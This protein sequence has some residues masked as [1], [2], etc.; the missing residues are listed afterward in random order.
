MDRN[1]QLKEIN[2]IYNCI[3]YFQME[4]FFGNF[5]VFLLFFHFSPNVGKYGPESLQIRA[6]FTQCLEQGQKNPVKLDNFY[7]SLCVLFDCYCESL[8]SWRQGSRLCL[9]PNLRCL[10]SNSFLVVVERHTISR[11]HETKAS[12]SNEN[13]IIKNKNCSVKSEWPFK[14]TILIFCL[15]KSQEWVRLWSWSISYKT[16]L[17]E[18]ISHR[19]STWVKIFDPPTL[20]AKKQKTKPDWDLYEVSSFDS[21]VVE[22]YHLPTDILCSFDGFWY[23][24]KL[25]VNESNIFRSH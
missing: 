23:L 21:R 3:L 5:L 14:S 7:I 12:L 6:L 1:Y 25:S 8:I 24:M 2:N 20:P 13:K 15:R 16:L 18:M 9:H 4:C 17:R 11:R 22:C 10:I 19:S